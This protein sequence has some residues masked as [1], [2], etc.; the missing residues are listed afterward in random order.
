MVA[1]HRKTKDYEKLQTLGRLTLKKSIEVSQGKLYTRSIVKKH[2][3]RIFISN[4]KEIY[5][6]FKDEG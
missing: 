1:R 3:R 4:T 2:N 6:K 5:F